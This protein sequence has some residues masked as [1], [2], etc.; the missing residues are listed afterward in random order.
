M[1]Y[2]LPGEIVYSREQC[3]WII[4][5]VF[6]M[7]AGNWP[8][9]PQDTGYNDVK[10]MTSPSRHAPY[11][12]PAQITGEIKRRLKPTKRDGKILV[13]QVLAGVDRF[14]ELEPEAKVALNYISILD[15]RKR[16]SYPTWRRERIGRYR[17]VN[18]TKRLQYLTKCV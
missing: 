7:E 8:I 15:F 17:V 13:W 1:D 18:T 3:I 14:E 9:N 11:E 16:G 12:I 4:S 2:Y 5:V 10:I 6:P